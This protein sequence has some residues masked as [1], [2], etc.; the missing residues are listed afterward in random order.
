MV[1]IG[2][3]GGLGNQMFQYA[4]YKKL[5]MEG[6]EVRIDLSFFNIKQIEAYRKF[7]LDIFNLDY[8]VATP[9][10]V[11]KLGDCSYSIW[12]KLRRKIFGQ[13]ASLYVED[14]DKGFQKEIFEKD[15]VYL[16]G[17]WQ[18]PNYFSDI[19]EDLLKCF[20]FPEKKDDLN[21]RILRKIR[22]EN[23]VSVHVRRGD[24]LSENNVQIYGNICTK[25]YYE[26]AMD[27]IREKIENPVFFLFTNDVEW[28][29]SELYKP[30]MVIV[31]CNIKKDCYY[32]MYLMSQCKANIIANSSFSWWGAWLNQN[33]QKIVIS[34]SKWFNNHQTTD[35]ICKEWIK[36]NGN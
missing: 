27:Y 9:K 34:P 6:R 20:T 17:Y 35:M 24:Y 13:K 16:Y 2:I 32:D 11:K 30:G 31:N 14:I 25:L 18:N 15:D 36:I 12:N 5:L 28:V 7:E 4:L 21:R 22:N 26:R 19:R 23:S 10:E 29:K 8:K 1:I 3:S 33:T